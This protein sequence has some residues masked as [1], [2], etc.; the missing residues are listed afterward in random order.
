[1]DLDHNLTQN[2]HIKTFLMRERGM[3]SDPK[4]E[5]QVFLCIFQEN[6]AMATLGLKEMENSFGKVGNFFCPV[7][8]LSLVPLSLKN[9]L[10]SKNKYNFS[11]TQLFRMFVVP[12]NS[13]A[14][15]C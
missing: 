5:Y 14:I 4:M 11:N 9:L 6:S 12:L 7:G 2:L 3:A 8:C 1:M 10:L 13:R 15:L